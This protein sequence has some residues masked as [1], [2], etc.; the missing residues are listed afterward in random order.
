MHEVESGVNGD[1]LIASRDCVLQRPEAGAPIIAQHYELAI[2]PQTVRRQAPD[3]LGYRREAIAPVVAVSGVEGNSLTVLLRQETEPVVL[4]LVKPVISIRDWF[5]F[6]EERCELGIY[7]GGEI[8][9][10]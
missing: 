8:G 3:L 5:A 6:W 9:F 10:D 7:P 2:E 4:D 1:C